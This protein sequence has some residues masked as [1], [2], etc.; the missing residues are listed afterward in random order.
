MTLAA[1][2]Y[3]L[4]HGETA[5]NT[6]RRMQG[7]KDSALTERGRLQA[8]AMGRTLKL[9]LAREPGPTVFLRSPLGRV[10]ETSEISA[11]RSASMP[12]NGAT[13]RGWPSSATA[14]GGSS[15]KEIELTYPTALADWRADPHG[16]CPPAGESHFELRRRSA[17]VLADI[18]ASATRTVVVG[19]GVSGAVLRG[20]NLGL[21]AKAMF[22]LEK[23]QDAF[24]RLL[25]GRESGLAARPANK[26]HRWERATPVAL[27][28]VACKDAQLELRAPSKDQPRDSRAVRRSRGLG[29]HQRA[30]VALG[31][32][33]AGAAV[34]A[35]H[36]GDADQRESAAG[37]GHAVDL[38]Q[39]GRR[40]RRRRVTGVGH[41]AAGSGVVGRAVDDAE[42][43]GEHVIERRVA[44]AAVARAA[45]LA[46][47][48]RSGLGGGGRGGGEQQQSR[49]EAPSSSSEQPLD[50]GQLE[51]DIGRPAVICTGR[52]CGVASIWRNSAFIS[53]TLSRRPARHRGVAGECAADLLDLLLERQVIAHLGQL[54]G[55]VAHQTLDIDLAQDRRR[56]AHHH[57]TQAKRLE[58]QAHVGQLGG[59]SGEP[60]RAILAHVDDLGQQQ[61]LALHA[62]G[63]E[64][65]LSGRSC[66]RPALV[67]GVLVDDHHAMVGL[68]DDIGLVQ[69]RARHAQRIG[70]AIAVLRLGGRFDARR[71][72]AERPP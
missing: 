67:G 43:D 62:V 70:R 47:E 46:I 50:V 7:T 30:A 8:I 44:R 21:D 15:W 32:E 71:Q 22:V 14:S 39:A 54:V 6:E 12:A 11:A 63:L 4:R 68:G 61:R 2:L 31:R 20:L 48:R 35:A 26:R 36:R 38:P 10:R 58:H 28:F 27:I 53:S 56:F 24:F 45:P 34:G 65:I 29:H 42:F 23:P 40:R 72:P 17:A 51:F 19:H 49:Q 37:L 33:L 9:E 57:G 41:R 55:E 16:Y 59:A 13:I 60:S 1:P 66:S 18:V 64:L 3:M 25:A 69:L 5:W 52:S